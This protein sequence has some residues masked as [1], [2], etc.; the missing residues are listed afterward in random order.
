MPYG[1]TNAPATFQQLIDRVLG[2]ES[3]P[4][5]Y[6][7]LHDIIIVAETF[8]KHKEYLKM[9]LERLVA[10]GLT[11]D[12]DKCVFCKPEVAYFGFLVNRDGMRP[13]SA[14]VEPIENYPTPKNLKDIWKFQGMASF[15]RWFI[16]RSPSHSQFPRLGDLSPIG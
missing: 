6:A 16:P 3:E 4:N 10:A 12:P 1:L 5:V 15:Y 11:L 7:N 9:V 13:N 2:P 14:K 8:E